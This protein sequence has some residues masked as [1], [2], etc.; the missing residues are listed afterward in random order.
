[1][2]EGVH[3]GG[4]RKV[5]YDVW[6]YPDLLVGFAA[7][8]TFAVLLFV[9]GFVVPGTFSV[10]GFRFPT[11]ILFMLMCTAACLFF[12]FRFKRM[13]VFDKNSYLGFLAAC[14]VMGVLFLFMESHAGITSI[15]F[16]VLALTLGMVLAAVGTIGIHIELGRILGMMGMTSTF[17]FGIASALVTAVAILGISLLSPLGKWGVAFLLPVVVV[18]AF[19][20]AKT[21]VFPDQKA[22]YRESTK[23]LLIP[24][25]FMATSVTQG[26]AVGIPL[27][28]L[29][30]SGFYD[31]ALDAAGYF[32]A[33]ILALLV[34]LVLQV[35]FNRA[36]YQ[37]GFP[38][39]ACG[40]LAV[41]VLGEAAPLAGVLQVTGFVYLDLVLWGL[42]S[43]LIKN[44]DQ[45]ATWLCSFP[46]TA[47]MIGRAVGIAIGSVSLQMA[48]GAGEM[49]LFF[50]VLAFL[51]LLAALQLTSNANMR[52]G[53]GFVRPG[54]PDEA[55]DSYR[56]CEVVAQDFGLTQRELE[57]MYSLV[58]GKSRKE[59]AEDL[60]ITSNTIKTHL[61][62]LY[63][64]LDIHSES[65]LKAFVSK[66]EKMF[67]T[68]EE[69]APPP[70]TFRGIVKG[71]RKSS[72]DVL[73]AD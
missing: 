58:E 3:R 12:A 18:V 5:V 55:T 34:V 72:G 10:G 50:C 22:L 13:H 60:Y 52:T 7:Y 11:L 48:M 63:G 20:R 26:L 66:R 62:N 33:A 15:G 35:D 43:Y 47:L 31:Q 4:V 56:T 24:Y 6:R 40:L 14:M 1:M 36:V 27:G 42:G 64:K 2:D 17:T 38:L 19:Y 57:I 41:G 54:D 61:H 67:S 45:P 16:Q 53:W 29:S 46:T 21:R 9:E 44:C 39:A 71:G 25:R 69:N 23:D 37:I 65:D 51:V 49:M 70:P 8:K 28:C 32:L 30:F 68:G 59:I 73:P